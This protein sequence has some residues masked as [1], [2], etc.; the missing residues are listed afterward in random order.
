MFNFNRNKAENSPVEHA[1]DADI[2]MEAYQEQ[3]RTLTNEA[4]RY[5]ME[6]MAKHDSD[7]PGYVGKYEGYAIS[8]EARELAQQSAEPSEA[9]AS[10]PDQENAA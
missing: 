5:T 3:Q 9:E 4:T 8:E 7:G 6:L 1:V 2:D 10:Q